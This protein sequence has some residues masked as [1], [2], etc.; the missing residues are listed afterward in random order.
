MSRVLPLAPLLLAAGCFQPTSTG[1]VSDDPSGCAGCRHSSSVQAGSGGRTST[2]RSL[3]ASSSSGGSGTG[4]S[5]SGTLSTSGGSS[6]GSSS[7]GSGGYFSDAGHYF[8]KDIAA[9]PLPLNCG[10]GDLGLASQ[11]VDIVD[12]STIAGG[13]MTSLDPD[14]VPISGSAGTTDAQGRFVLCGSATAPFTVEATAASYPITYFAEVEGVLAQRL[15]QIG[16]VSSGFLSAMSALVPGGIDLGRG[17]VVVKVSNSVL[18]DPSTAGWTIALTLPDGGSVPDGGYQLLYNGAGG[19]PQPG[20]T[21]TS[22]AGPAI[23]FDIDPQLGNFFVVSYENADAGACTSQND[24]EGFTGRVYV[25]GN[26]VALFPILL[27]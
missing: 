13:N 22:A 10:A 17:T 27:P 25:A 26:S 4:S 11:L 14:G 8:C 24:S 1:P 9:T 12:C 15:V 7:G 23:F 19:L 5:G 6:G 20:L 21:S 18:C 16:L 3:G 2:V